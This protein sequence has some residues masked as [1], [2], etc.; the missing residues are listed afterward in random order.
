MKDILLFSGGADSA[1]IA[2]KILT[3]TDNELTT[4][5]LVNTPEGTTSW[6]P[7]PRFLTRIDALIEE[8]KKIRNFTSIKKPVLDSEITV[9][10]DHAY[11]YGIEWASSFINDGTYDRFITG[12]TWEQQ[13]QS[14][15]KGSTLKGTPTYFASI[16][17]WNKLV[18]RGELYD[19]LVNDDYNVNFNRYDLFNE[20]PDNIKVHTI[21][22]HNPSFNADGTDVI[23]CGKCFKCLWD[24]KTEEFISKGYTPA[25]LN[26]WRRIKALEYGGGNSVS[27][28]MR[29]WLPI[30]MGKGD[31]LTVTNSN[32]DKVKLN[33]KEKIQNLAQS[34]NHYTYKDRPKTGIWDFSN[35]LNGV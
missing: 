2:Y 16:N 26:A 19:P 12:R 9:E 17:L 21:S 1:Y 4:L 35:F 28:P 24:E 27:A 11:L 33:T 34:E 6:A 13:N 20:L 3:E 8:L 31:I 14:L 15:F 18:T 30:E 5:T 10:N 32:G 22:C 29:Y 25:Q 7:K 23:E